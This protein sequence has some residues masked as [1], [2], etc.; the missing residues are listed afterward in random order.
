MFRVARRAGLITVGEQMI[1]PAA[2]EWAEAER[3]HEAWPGWEDK[4]DRRTYD[5][6][7][8]FEEATWAAADR[9]G[10][11]SEYVRHGLVGQGVSADRVALVPYPAEVGPFEYVDRRGRTGPLTVGFVGQVN[12]RKNAPTVFTVARRFRPTEVRFVMVGRVYLKA[13][14]VAAHKGE[15]E[16]TGPLPRSEVPGRLAGFDLFLFPS[17]CEGSAGAVIEAMATGLPV[18]TTP[19]SGS[20]VRDG[21][22]GFVL[23]PGDVD[24][25]ARRIAEL[26]ADP[27]CRHALGAAARER[28]AGLTLDRY[29]RELAAVFDGAQA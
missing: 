28:V 24:G 11:P 18:L 22:D 26:A 25:F 7:R 16:L 29:G 3:Q 27:D 13:A 20:P 2:V 23:A 4:P 12:L 10:A 5:R 21:V 6:L 1:A 8:R 17:T 9:L 14:A 19:N 15:V